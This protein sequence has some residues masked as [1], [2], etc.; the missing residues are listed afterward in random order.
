MFDAVLKHYKINIL[1]IF[2]LRSIETKEIA[3]VLL[4]EMEK[5]NV[6]M[7]SDVNVQTRYDDRYCWTLHFYTS[8][9][10]LHLD[11]RSQEPEKAKTCASNRFGRNLIY[12][13]FFFFS[14]DKWK[15][16]SP[17]WRWQYV[18]GP[19][20]CRRT[21]RL[22]ECGQARFP[23]WA[24]RRGGRTAADVLFSYRQYRKSSALYGQL[25]V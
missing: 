1:I 9:C 20:G 24:A 6:G 14:F 25:G 21:C 17:R 19:P 12:S 15:L 7:H 5:K 13:S 18:A 2:W 22:R 23:F 4:T 11:P 10:D 16:Q 8:L 3:A